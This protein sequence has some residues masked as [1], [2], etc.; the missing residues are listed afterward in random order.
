M[1]LPAFE[2]QRR[3]LAELRA[4]GRYTGMDEAA[5]RAARQAVEDTI[6]LDEFYRIEEETVENRPHG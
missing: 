2:A 5:C 4:T 1:L 6:G 3:M